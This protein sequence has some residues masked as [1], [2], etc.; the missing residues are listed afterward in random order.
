MLRGSASKH[1][2]GVAHLSAVAAAMAA[3]QLAAEDDN[4]LEEPYYDPSD[5]Y[6]NP[7]AG[8]AAPEHRIGL[9]DPALDDMPDLEPCDDDG[10]YVGFTSPVPTGILPHNPSTEQERLRQQV[11][12]L[13]MQAEQ[14]DEFGGLADSDYDSTISEIVQQ[15]RLLGTCNLFPNRGSTLIDLADLDDSTGDTVQPVTE[16]PAANGDYAPY[17][18]KMVCVCMCSCANQKRKKTHSDVNR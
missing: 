5:V 13:L 4:R 14:D 15:F 8:T 12:A 16:S 11:Q 10:G 2:L 6:I 3:S 9:F 17:P 18:S 1:I 7:D